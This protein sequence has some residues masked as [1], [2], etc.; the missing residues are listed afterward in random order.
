MLI[1]DGG[2]L[3]TLKTAR[4]AFLLQRLKIGRD[5]VRGTGELLLVDRLVARLRFAVGGFARLSLQDI[6]VDRYHLRLAVQLGK[7]RQ[8]FVDHG[9]LGIDQQHV[10]GRVG[11]LYVHGTLEV[12]DQQRREVLGG[13]MLDDIGKALGFGIVPESVRGRSTCAASSRGFTQS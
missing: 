8:Q 11:G 13:A 1:L 6:H 7:R 4:G 5:F 9:G 10:A 12:L 2:H 3:E